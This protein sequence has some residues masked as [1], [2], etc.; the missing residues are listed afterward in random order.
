VH[1]FTDIVRASYILWI[2]LAMLAAFRVSGGDNLLSRRQ[3]RV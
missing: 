3:R 2:A 1:H